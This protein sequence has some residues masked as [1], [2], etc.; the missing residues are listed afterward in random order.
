MPKPTDMRPKLGFGATALEPPPD[1][2]V[3]E[4]ARL[5]NITKQSLTV[6][7]ACLTEVD[8]EATALELARIVLDRF[9][10]GIRP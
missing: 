10:E 2:A 1:P 4:K 8:D 3:V 5:D 7:R 6:F 9:D